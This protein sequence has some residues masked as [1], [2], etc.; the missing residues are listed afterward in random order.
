MNGS[1][2][3]FTR[4]FIRAGDR[5]QAVAGWIVKGS[6][7]TSLTTNQDQMKTRLLAVAVAATTAVTP[8]AAWAGTYAA[9]CGG[10]NCTVS[11]TPEAIKS[12]YGEIPPSR[13]TYWGS[14]GESKT[15]IGTGVATTILFG[16]IGLLG[17][18]AKTHQYN[19]TI[20]GFDADGKK[21][22]MQIEFKNDKP[23]KQL[24]GELTAFTGLGM[25]QTRTAE[26]ILAAESGAEATL[27]SLGK[28]KEATILGPKALNTATE[29][30]RNCWSAYIN[31]NPE[32]LNWA[33]TNPLQ[34][35]QNK[36]R[37][38]DC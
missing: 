12:S 25:G 32:M 4:G 15:S 24:M 14:T 22:S 37:F 5:R 20:N 19:F 34:A 31:K 17:F 10:I 33:N 18:L 11:I 35:T 13:V 23:A 6:R 36:K 3:Q 27:Q 30:K 28:S 1:G 9:L 21:A 2:V 38:D 7:G 16:G 26:E 29:A 8:A